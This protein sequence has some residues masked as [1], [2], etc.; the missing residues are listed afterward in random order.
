MKQSFAILFFIVIF[1]FLACADDEDPCDVKH[2]VING[3][4]VPDYIF[5]DNQTVEN[6]AK[7]YH[8]KFGVIIYQ[9]GN[10]IDEWNHLIEELEIKTH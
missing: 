2:V 3:E 4:C 6:G 1:S 8:K 5:P 9:D 7:F 10:W